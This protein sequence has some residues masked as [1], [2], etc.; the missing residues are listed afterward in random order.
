MRIAGALIAGNVLPGYEIGGDWFDYAD[1]RD[2]AWIGIVD[3]EGQG[4]Q[5]AGLGAVT[6]GAFRAARHHCTDPAVVVRAMHEAL[7]E[8][9]AGRSQAD[10][11]IAT[12]SGPTSTIRWVTCG[13]RAP[14]LITAAGEVEVLDEGALPRLGKRGLPTQPKVQERRLKDGDRLLLLSDGIIERPTLGGGTL[15]VDGVREAVSNAPR[16]SAAGTV[17]AIEDAVRESVE[18]LLS[19]D[20]TLVVLVPNPAVSEAG[21]AAARP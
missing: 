14:I 8:V 21:A 7:R 11:T 17:R 19:D 6:L 4:A 10:T 13:E 12:W 3:T 5:A 20:A 2:C 9:T 18:D 1:N 16:A 15:G